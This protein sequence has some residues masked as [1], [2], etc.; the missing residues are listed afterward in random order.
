[1]DTHD[2]EYPLPSYEDIENLYQYKCPNCGEG[3]KNM[4]DICH[5]PKEGEELTRFICPNCDH[6]TNSQDDYEQEPQEIYEWWIVTEYLYKKLIE[7]GEA[8]IEWGNNCYWGR[9]SCGQ[10]ILLDHVIS[11]ICEEMEILDGQKYS[12]AK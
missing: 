12:W 11:L 8:G 9:T 6:E 3:A 5:E 10:A 4:D 2:K 7:R 1:M